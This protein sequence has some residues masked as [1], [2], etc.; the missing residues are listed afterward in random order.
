MHWSAGS[1][2]EDLLSLARAGDGAALGRLLQSYRSY[3]RLLAQVQIDRRLRGKADPSDVVQDAYLYAQ[4]AFGSFRGRT[5]WELLA[6][7]RKILASKLHDLARRFCVA[8]LRDVRLE[9]RLDDEL[10]Q[11]SAMMRQLVAAGSSPSQRAVRRERAAL[12]AD[13]LARLPQAYREVIVLRH[14]EGLSFGEI[15][16]HMDRSEESVKKVW[17]RAL[18]ALRRSFKGGNSGSVF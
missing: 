17:I 5:E 12:V 2:P 15:G 13:A 9:R 18:S 10:E 11:S 1:D 14:M 16:R 4:H 3:L 6:W 8:Q 7:L